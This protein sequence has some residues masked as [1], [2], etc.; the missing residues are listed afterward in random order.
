MRHF[1]HQTLGQTS[2]SNQTQIFQ[3]GLTERHNFAMTGYNISVCAWQIYVIE[4]QLETKGA[5]AILNLSELG[6]NE[7]FP[8]SSSKKSFKKFDSLKK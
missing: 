5:N 7:Y 8:F 6:K 4:N 3:S 2:Q 1:F